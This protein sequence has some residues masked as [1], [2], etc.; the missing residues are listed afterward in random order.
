MNS[1]STYQE[2]RAFAI[3]VVLFSRSLQKSAEAFII[4]KQL[5]KSVSS[6]AANYRAS[7]CARS[8]NEWHAKISIVYE[9]IDE[10]NFWLEFINELKLSNKQDQLNALIDESLAFAKRFAKI[11]SS[12][13]E[14]GNHLKYKK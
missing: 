6:S 9:E 3:D 1:E 7:R 8:R 11:R 5:I 4:Q 12:S 13:K 10:T 2:L 14:N